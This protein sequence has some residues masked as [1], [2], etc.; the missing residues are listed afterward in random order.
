MIKFFRRIRQQ[1]LSENKFSKYLLYAI[2]EIVLVVIGILIALQINNWNEGRKSIKSTELLLTQVRKELVFNITKAN[3]IISTYRE[4]DSL[5]YRILNKEV[6]FADYKSNPAYFG[7][8]LGQEAVEISNDAFLNLINSQGNFT[9]EEDTIIAY[10]K[11][12]YGA[13]KKRVDITDEIT[14]ENVL[15]NHKNLKNEKEWYYDF[16]MNEETPDE[17]IEYCLTSPFYLNNVASFHFFNLIN[18][19]MYTSVFRNNAIEI[20]KNLSNYLKIQKDTSIIKNLEDYNH[21]LGNFSRNNAYS[22]EIKKQNENL[23]FKWQNKTDSTIS[24]QVNIYPDSQTHFTIG[25]RFGKFI[26]GKNQNVTGLIIS[27]GKS[28]TEY[29]K[30]NNIN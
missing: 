13:N 1:L 20:Y 26:Y 3:N 14:K 17:T 30:I 10:L 22:Y 19:N 6:S 11:E 9:N 23:I 21:Y 24:G 5:V 15:D 2:G 12:L 18:H 25:S 7:I 8:L 28:R 16:V 27:L 4:K 29:K